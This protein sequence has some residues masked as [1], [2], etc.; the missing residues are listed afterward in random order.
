MTYSLQDARAQPHGARASLIGVCG[1]YWK[2]S[3]IESA[4]AVAQLS[5]HSYKAIL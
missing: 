2:H 5:W 3:M 1:A 4:K